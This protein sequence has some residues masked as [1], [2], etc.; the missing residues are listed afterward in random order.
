MSDEHTATPSPQ[1]SV[2]ITDFFATADLSSYTDDLEA[3]LKAGAHFG[4]Q[5]S[6]R[7]P[8][9]IPY[10]FTVRGGVTIIDLEKTQRGIRSA[11]EFLTSVR[12]SGKH[13][14]FVTTKKQMLDLLKSAA[15]RADE[16]YVIERWIGGTFTNFPQIRS[17]VKALLKM[18]ED[19]EK[20]VFLKYTKL[21]QLRKREEIAKL[22]R[23]MG[24]LKKMDTLP[25]AIVVL[26]VKADALAVN[27]ARKQG[28]PVVA[29][30]DTNIDVSMVDYPIP[31][32]DD[33]IS[34]VK[35]I[36]G[37]LLKA[38]D[39]VVAAPPKTSKNSKSVTRG[40]K[41]GASKKK[42]KRTAKTASAASSDAKSNK[43]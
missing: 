36:L 9:M 28:I 29:I 35:T 31:A 25:G 20:G 13:I 43:K 14:L 24:G 41:D 18:E 27:E 37:L 5:K 23:K 34:S 15:N 2:D 10:I 33:A 4:H 26:D 32:N 3:L 6:R 1:Q 16:P 11:A 17:R 22:N 21:E 42:T 7:H 30:A 19:M 38:L 12:K 40:S 39:G 8:R